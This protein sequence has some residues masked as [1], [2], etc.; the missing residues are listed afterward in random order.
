MSRGPSVAHRLSCG[1]SQGPARRGGRRPGW[2]PTVA[3]G[4]AGR[5]RCDARATRAAAVPPSAALDAPR[6]SRRPRRSGACGAGLPLASLRFSPPHKSPTP[7]AARRAAPLVACGEA[8]RDGAG[9]AGGGY[10]PAATLRGAEERRVARVARRPE[11][12]RRPHTV[13][14]PSAAALR[15]SVA[16][17]RGR[18]CV[19][20]LAARAP[21]GSR[22][23]GPTAVHE[24][25]RIPG[26]GF[27][28]SASAGNHQ[29]SE[30]SR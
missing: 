22:P 23:A 27:A 1:T 17:A 2:T 29:T 11:A 4:L 13:R 18:V 20:A 28:R 25:R 3:V 30:S 10:A 26:H 19:A 7:G 21:Q 15:S 8:C 16:A 6:T 14:V 9:K 12:T 24:R 5:L